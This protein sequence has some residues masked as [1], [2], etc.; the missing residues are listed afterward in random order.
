VLAERAFGAVDS[1]GHGPVY[2]EQIDHGAG[3]IEIKGWKYPDPLSVS[4]TDHYTYA[5]ADGGQR[6]VGVADILFRPR[7][8]N[9]PGFEGRV[10]VNERD[11]AF[12]YAEYR[13]VNAQDLPYVDSYAVVQRYDTENTKV[14]F[15]VYQQI[16]AT[17]RVE[18]LTGIATG[19]YDHTSTRTVVGV[20]MLNDSVPDDRSSETV[21][22]L[23]PVRLITYGSDTLAATEFLRERSVI[24][25]SA[26]R[27]MVS[28]ANTRKR[29]RTLDDIDLDGV[30]LTRVQ[31]VDVR[32]L[33][34]FFRSQRA[35]MGWGA[36][37][38]LGYG[39]G[40]LTLTFGRSQD[41]ESI[42]GAR[43]S[44]WLSSESSP[45]LRVDAEYRSTVATTQNQIV[46]TG[47]AFQDML[48]A[49]Y[50]SYYSYYREVATSL[51][52]AYSVDR[53]DV[54]MNASHLTASTLVPPLSAWS[55]GVWEDLN[56][57]YLVAD[58]NVTFGGA[59]VGV[60]RSAS[61]AP[62]RVQ[63]R[64]RGGY[65]LTSDRPLTTAAI[66][67]ENGFTMLRTPW[68]NIGVR[69]GLRGGIVSDETPSQFALSMVPRFTFGGLDADHVT[70]QANSLFGRWLVG[71]RLE[72]D[73]GDLPWRIVGLPSFNGIAPKFSLTASGTELN[74]VA[75]FTDG[76]PVSDR[77]EVREAGF[78]V[79]S[80]P[81][82]FTALVQLDVAASW[83]L[84]RSTSLQ[85][86]FRVVF[87]LSV[88]FATE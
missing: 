34:V 41:R 44:V 19:E 65:G 51:G 3:F 84:V 15:P 5:Y 73:L 38:T 77:V 55:S 52:V 56:G 81:L 86:P 22:H 4:G 82:L 37:L 49:A 79:R 7:D 33:P 8:R 61:E 87:D 32:L 57:R 9:A 75:S 36:G 43:A 17:L 21:Q 11:T 59:P 29:E 26:I 60:Q 58:V 10:Q 54:S 69:Y 68:A 88:P 66:D 71:A 1:T 46:K 80:V 70:L 30:V 12:V 64:I 20:L 16:K 74:R 67:I 18:I 50:P 25:D 27:T 6:Q 78:R 2:D 45:R 40:R 14:W 76:D 48:R 83:S 63:A 53:L 85:A 72:L 13:L 47:G 35:E 62:L 28:S 39:P 31:G 42:H 23:T 24:A